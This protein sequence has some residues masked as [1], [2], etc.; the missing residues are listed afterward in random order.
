VNGIG[1]S[2]SPPMLNKS[3]VEMTACSGRWCSDAL[4]NVVGTNLDGRRAGAEVENFTEKEKRILTV[5]GW[6]GWNVLGYQ[7]GVARRRVA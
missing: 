6:V 1:R 4:S 7:S 2:S 3:K 5:E